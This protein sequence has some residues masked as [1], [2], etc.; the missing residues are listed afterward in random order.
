MKSLFA[1]IL[2]WFWC[3]LAITVVGSALHLGAQRESAT[4]TT[5]SP[6]A[7]CHP[8]SWKKRGTRTRTA[9]APAL[10]AFLDNASRTSTTRGG[11]LTDDDGRDLLTNEDRSDLVGARARPPG[12]S[13]I[14]RAAET[15][16][17]ARSDDGQYWFFFIVPRAQRPAV[18]FLHAA[19][20][21]SSWAPP[22][23]SATGWRY[24]LDQP[25]A[26]AAKGRRALR[27]RRSF[28]RAPAPRGA[29]SSANWRATFDRWR[30]ASRRCWPPSAACCSTS[31]TSCARRWRGS[32]WRWN[33]RA[34]ATIWTPR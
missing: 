31:R 22:C 13:A 8:S 16:V 18:W 33:W 7:R 21:C 32:E 30:T 23:C 1:K 34:R 24:H 27:P 25:G 17:R 2:L 29:T 20:T 11:I 5:S 3:T 9:D 14:I 26:R 15:I 19:N 28:A 6:V 4:T 12:V 10:Q